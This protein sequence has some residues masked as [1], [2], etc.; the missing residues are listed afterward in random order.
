VCA[1]AARPWHFTACCAV[2]ANSCYGS[3]CED[4]TAAEDFLFRLQPDA[5]QRFDPIPGG[6]TEYQLVGPGWWPVWGVYGDL[7]MGYDGPPGGADG[8]CSQGSTYSGSPN[9]AC[10]GVIGTWGRTDMEA[11]RPAQ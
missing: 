5:P 9:E 3:L 8:Y 2:G 7:T 11:W 4:H 10:G 6:N 1:Q